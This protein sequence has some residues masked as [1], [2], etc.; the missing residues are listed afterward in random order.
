MAENEF[1]PEALSRQLIDLSSAGPPLH[2]YNR[3]FV[4]IVID[5]VGALAATLWLLRENELVAAAGPANRL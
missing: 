5:A 4:R 2:S 1:A 3:Q